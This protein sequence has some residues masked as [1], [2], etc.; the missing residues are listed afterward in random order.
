VNKD[1][2]RAILRSELDKYRVR[3]YAELREM[4]NAPPVAFELRRPSG[5]EY[6]VEIE[7]VW[8]SRQEGDIR[9]I[10]SIGDGGWRAFVPLI[11]SFIKAP[12]GLFVGEN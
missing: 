12:D 7:A 1:E 4:L 5:A 8:D 9:V 3:T 2:A 10:A 6:Q 11:A